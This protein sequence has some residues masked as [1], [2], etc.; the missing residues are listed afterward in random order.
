MSSMGIFVVIIL[1]RGIVIFI[2]AIVRI[3]DF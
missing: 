1:A 2:L 3:P